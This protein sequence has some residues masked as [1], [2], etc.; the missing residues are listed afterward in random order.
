VEPAR[1][2]AGP[3]L[4]GG[5][6]AHVQ[7]L[8][9][10]A[11]RRSGCARQR[12]LDRAEAVYSGMVPGFVAGH[13]GRQA[14][15]RRGGAG[16][17]LRARAILSAATRGPGCAASTS[18][19]RRR[20]T[21]TSPASTSARR[22]DLPACARTRRPIRDLVDRLERRLASTTTARDASLRVALVGGGGHRARLL[23]DARLRRGGRRGELTLYESEHALSLPPGLARRAQGEARRRGI[24]I[25]T[26]AGVTRVEANELWLGAERVP[27]DLVVWATGAAPWPWLAASPLPRSARGFVRVRPASG[28][29]PRRAVRRRRLHRF[30]GAPWRRRASTRCARARRSTPICAHISPEAAWARID[31]SAISCR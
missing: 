5:G 17:A 27:V 20:F 26:G 1:I 11:Q 22:L 2:A 8:R 13:Y 14:R 25:R 30:E 9:R 18:P 23:P 6:H 7:V 19:A 31:R 3:V 24:G 15:D 28:G 10:L 4:V 12:L 29:R 21:T 16:A